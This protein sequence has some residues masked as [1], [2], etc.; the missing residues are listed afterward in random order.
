MARLMV[1][2]RTP[3]DVAAF[4][5]YYFDKHVPTAKKIPGLRKYEVN[6]GPVMTPSVKGLFRSRPKP[7]VLCLAN[8]SSSTNEPA[9]S[10]SSRR[11]RAVSFPRACWRSV[12]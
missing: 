3:K 12:A 10:N 7:L 5:R 4:D 11:S 6:A 9:S 2:Y 8:R 1:L